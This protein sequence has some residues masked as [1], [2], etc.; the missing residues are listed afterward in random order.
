MNI[1]IELV[2]ILHFKGAENLAKFFL[3]CNK[4]LPIILEYEF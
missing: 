1:N 2:S 4:F 3:I